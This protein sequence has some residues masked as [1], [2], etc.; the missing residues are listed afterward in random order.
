M[1]GESVSRAL[2]R[3]AI[4]EALMDAMRNAYDRDYTLTKSD[5]N[6]GVFIAV[7]FNSGGENATFYAS[8]ELNIKDILHSRN[9]QGYICG[10]FIR[11]INRIENEMRKRGLD[12]DIDQTKKS[13][14]TII[15]C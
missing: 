7:S 6:M 13:F 9:D 2:N 5:R 15:T 10:R 8:E 4:E 12:R 14:P 3:A 1:T 11:L